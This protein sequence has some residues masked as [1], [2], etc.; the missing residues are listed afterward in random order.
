MND[1]TPMALVDSLVAQQVP[2]VII[3]GHAVNFH[4]HLRTTE[5]VDIIY[6]RTRQSV[7]ALYNVLSMAEAFRIDNEIDPA[8]GIEKTH[9]ITKAEVG[10]SHLLMLGTKHGYIDIFDFIPGL[11][12]EPLDDL[13][14]SA[15]VAEG[16]PFASLDWL[17]RMKQATGRPRD[18]EDLKH[19][20]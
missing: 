7:E 12:E 19:L 13:F 4:G 1:S 15:V 9:Q 18:L 17:K 8:T 10:R 14:A 2:F 16:R 6:R 11:P 5:D 20:P 3:G